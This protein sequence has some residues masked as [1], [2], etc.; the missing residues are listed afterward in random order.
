LVT[1]IEQQRESRRQI[2]GEARAT[3][4]LGSQIA[5]AALSTRDADERFEPARRRPDL[6][7]D[8][9]GLDVRGVD[10]ERLEPG[11]KL[12]GA[13]TLEGARGA[14]DSQAGSADLSRIVG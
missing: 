6:D 13:R 1:P 4:S 9:D 5:H 8:L 2:R 11:K 3:R 10:A 7:V 12:R 14:S